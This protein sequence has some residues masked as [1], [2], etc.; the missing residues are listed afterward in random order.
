MVSYRTNSILGRNRQGGDPLTSESKF[1]TPPASPSYATRLGH[2]PIEPLAVRLEST[3]TQLDIIAHPNDRT[4]ADEARLATKQDGGSR[5]S[6]T[7]ASHAWS[8][9]RDV[10]V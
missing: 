4:F 10:Y 5:T 6:R 8:R 3:R 7:L 2:G 9:L 1:A